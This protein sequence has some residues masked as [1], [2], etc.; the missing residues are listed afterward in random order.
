MAEID[1]QDNFE[2]WITT[3][4]AARK[5]GITARWVRE[6]IDKNKLVGRLVTSR[7]WMVS[8]QS[9]EDYLREEK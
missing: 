2:N 8:R 1:K 4:E 6:L 5:I 9:V 7:L 3:A